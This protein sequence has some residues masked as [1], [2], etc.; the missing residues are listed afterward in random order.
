MN[1]GKKVLITFLGNIN[2]D[3]RCKNLFNTLNAN[4]Y[5]VS[6]IG[7][8]WLTENF[9][10]AKG[11]ITIHK[12][13]KG[14]LSLSFYIKYIWLIK[15]GLLSSRASVYFAEDIYTLPFAFIFGKI[16]RAKVYYDS[17]ELFGHLAGLKEKRTRQR[18]WRMV[19][20]F[21]IS[22]VDHIIVT[23]K[24]DAEFIEEKYNVDNTIILR[25]LPR[26]YKPLVKAD[27]H[28]K[29]GID[30][31]K[32]ILLYQGVLLRGRGI[33]FIYDVLSKLPNYVFL[34]VGGGEFEEYYKKLATGMGLI[35]QVYFLGKVKIEDLPEITQAA[36]VGIA[37]VEN[38]SL[39]YYYALPNKLFEYIMAEVPVIVSNLPQM[40]EVVEK[41]NV[42]IA[43]QP[44]NK[45]ELLEALEKLDLDK[46]FYNKLKQNCK[47]ASEELNWEK[48]VTGLLKSI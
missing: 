29:L 31:S 14:F 3:S 35:E 28:T 22:K 47:I 39:S 16:R 10:P 21:F 33:E 41:F 48:E 40:K 13:H 5:D 42:G 15:T 9:E 12:L 36:D 11:K 4:G 38:L 25:N 17:R 19:E 32:K 44:D 34:I 23:G 24:M 18:F 8:D 43:L 30:K 6:F 7:F 2:Y 26:F 20:K 27:L 1:T 37:L 46:Q 45:K